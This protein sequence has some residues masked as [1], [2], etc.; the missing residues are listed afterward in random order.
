MPCSAHL[1]SSCYSQ[2]NVCNLKSLL[3]DTPPIY[4]AGQNL[5]VDQRQ[6]FLSDRMV[7]QKSTV[8]G[9]GFTSVLQKSAMPIV[10]AIPMPGS[11]APA[12]PLEILVIQ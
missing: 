3:L 10:Q 9:E 4:T 6:T 7:P 12:V 8:S 2:L 1:S 11:I 5:W